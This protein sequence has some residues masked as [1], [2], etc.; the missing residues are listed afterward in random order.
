MTSNKKHVN[1]KV[2]DHIEY[3]NFGAD[4]VNVRDHLANK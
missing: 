4:R 3:L 2:V 1:Y